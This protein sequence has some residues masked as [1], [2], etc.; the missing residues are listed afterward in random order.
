MQLLADEALFLSYELE[1][2]HITHNQ[3]YR[4]IVFFK[5]Q[6]W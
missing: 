4:K 1:R 2:R 6:I 5:R 3:K